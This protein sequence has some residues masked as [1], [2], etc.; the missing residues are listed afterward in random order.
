LPV[1]I[2]LLCADTNIAIY[3]AQGISS[4]TS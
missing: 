3:I 1:F 2:L 4:K